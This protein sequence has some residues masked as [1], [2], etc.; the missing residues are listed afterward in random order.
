M[1]STGILTQ[2]SCNLNF[3]YHFYIS[4]SFLFKFHR[5]LMRWNLISHS[6]YFLFHTNMILLSLLLAAVAG[7]YEQ[8][9]PPVTDSCSRF[10][11]CRQQLCLNKLD[12]IKDSRFKGSCDSN[13]KV[14][15]WIH[16]NHISSVTDCCKGILLL[17]RYPP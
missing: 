15:L 2:Y 8:R 16:I 14:F 5:P 11:N 10:V 4:E 13:R 3:I 9:Y 1:A 12:T 7:G 6:C 17:I